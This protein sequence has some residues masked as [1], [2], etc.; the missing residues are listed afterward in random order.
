MQYG[1]YGATKMEK[2]HNRSMNKGNSMVE[3][4]GCLI[5]PL[6]VFLLVFYLRSFDSHYKSESFTDVM[7][8]CVLIVPLV[9]GMNAFSMRKTGDP[10]PMALLALMA[11]GAWLSAVMLGD[12]N[13]HSNMRP[14][15]DVRQLNVYPSVDT[16]KYSGQSLMD[17]GILEFAAGTKLLYNRSVGFK[18]Q[19]IYCVA[20]IASGSG[21]Q[22]VYDF[23]A[24]GM[25]CCSAKRADFHCGDYTSQKSM[26][27]LRVLDD[28]KRDMFRL[29][30]KKA[31]A[32][33]QLKV[34]HPV[35]VY[36]LSDPESELRAY[37]EDGWQYYVTASFAFFCIELLLVVLATVAFSKM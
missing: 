29:V 22:S 34:N 21:N 14:F 23:W 4:L 26:K 33:F 8:Y 5:V 17:A 1:S 31:E 36:W 25:N 32:E 3:L 35:F 15:Y 11:L 13:F 7:C 19:D 27:G 24:V 28:E 18:N 30:V 2:E 37:Q 6:L 12:F 20:P 10:K 16:A 9:A